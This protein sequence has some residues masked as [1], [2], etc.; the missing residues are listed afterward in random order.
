MKNYL[1]IALEAYRGYANYLW[2]DITHPGLHSYFY[3]L[4]FVSVVFFV[5]EVIIPWRKKQAILRRDFFLD[6]FY[7]FFNFFLFSLV[8]YNAA[9]SVVV[10]LFN[11]GI[12]SI[13]NGFELLA[14][15]PMQ[16]WPLWAVLLVGFVLRDFVQWWTH[17]LLHRVEFLWNF[18]R[19]HHSVQEMGFA[20]HLRY[21]WME[22]VVYRTI[23]YIPLA[24]LGIGLYDFFIIHL[25]TLAWGH[26]N[27]ANLR[28]P[29]WVS[30]GI[31]G[32][33][34]GLVIG[35]ASFE[36][37]LVSDP[38]W[39]TVAAGAIGG[40]AFGTSLLRYVMP[41]LFNSPEMHIWHHAKELPEDRFHGVNF[42]LTLA[43]WDYLFGTN[44]IPY[45]GQNIDLGFEGIESFPD[46]FAG[47]VVI[48]MPGT[49]DK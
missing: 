14:S 31:V 19:V 47:Q 46:D 39:V 11:N 6:V 24:L 37:G 25:F 34:V 1:D 29:T 27:H 10:E 18:H 33:L 43:V 28:L 20:A 7:M 36:V 8:V 49:A 40:L 12:A 2:N 42:G 9:A 41:Y 4:I 30:G 17:R 48:G 13:F 21:H 16:T 44:Y 26:Y 45:D 32:A 15:N 23:E 3:M 22:T 5:L 35:S 38:N